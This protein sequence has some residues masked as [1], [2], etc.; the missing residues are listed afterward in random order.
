[1]GAKIS[2]DSASMM[3]KGLEFIEAYHLFPVGWIGCASSCI[4]SRSSI[5][6]SNIAMVL[7]WR[8]WADMRVPIASCLAW[9]ERMETP[10]SDK[11]DLA[12]IGELTFRAPDETRFP[13]TRLAR[14]AAHAGGGIPA[15]LN[16]ANEIA[17]DAFLN[18]RIGFTRI[19]TMVEDVLS[20]YAPPPPAAIEDVHE[21]TR[22]PA[23]TPQ[24]CWRSPESWRNR[25]S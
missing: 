6:W 8:N 9:P 19:P 4:P 16:A 23:A 10:L 25:R 5:R 11:L 3:N 22:R 15:V 20:A 17:V 1:M 21:L 2:V 18:G 13:A 12:A 7:R 14:Q 24:P